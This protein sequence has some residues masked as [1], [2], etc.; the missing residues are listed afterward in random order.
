MNN[1]KQ[2]HVAELLTQGAS[3]Y[4]EALAAL[5]EFRR[6][7]C[8]AWQRGVEQ[9]IADISQAMSLKLS[10]SQIAAYVNPDSLRSADGEF[11]AIG[12]SLKNT[13]WTLYFYTLWW[14]GLKAGA[15]IWFKD[16]SAARATLTRLKQVKS[17]LPVAE[18][19]KEVYIYKS[20]EPDDLGRIDETVAELLDD[21][22]R[23]W[24]LAGGCQLQQTPART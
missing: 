20:L 5:A 10:S 18:E 16:A 17:P 24:T 3:S 11:A 15:S 1:L 23:I 21:W 8:A 7:L 6:E 12:V 4:P 19:S 22:C 13:D 2:Q 14:D 9:R